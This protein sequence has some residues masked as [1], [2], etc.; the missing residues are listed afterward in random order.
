MFHARFKSEVDIEGTDD[1]TYSFLDGGVLQITRASDEK[2]LYYPP[3]NWTRVQA[4]L[5]HP[6]G[7]TKGAD[8]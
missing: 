7:H 4:D 6:P 8:L 3:D 1:D 2:A 5:D